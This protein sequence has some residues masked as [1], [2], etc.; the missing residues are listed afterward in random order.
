MVRE[1][2]NE[3]SWMDSFRAII[4]I[5]MIHTDLRSLGIK[6]IIASNHNVETLR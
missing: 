5:Y 6:V 2:F 1:R 3:A 4:T